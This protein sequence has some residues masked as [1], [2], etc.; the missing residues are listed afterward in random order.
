MK[1]PSSHDVYVKMKH[2]LPGPRSIIDDGAES[3]RVDLALAS[4]LRGDGEEMTQQRLI[5]FFGLGEG[6]NVPTRDH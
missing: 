5:F 4:K 1:Y 2:R 3:L 6:R